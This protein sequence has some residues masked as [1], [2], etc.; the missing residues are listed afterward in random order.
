MPSSFSTACLLFSEVA[1][2]L[3]YTAPHP[4]GNGRRISPRGRTQ[5]L[6][7]RT[8]PSG[9]RRRLVDSAFRKAGLS[10]RPR[11]VLDTRDAVYEAVVNRMGVGFM[12]RHGT[13]RTDAIRRIGVIG[14]APPCAESVFRLQGP[15]DTLVTAFFAAA[16][17]F[18]RDGRVNAM[19][20]RG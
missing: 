11:L 8:E 10:P 19:S 12:W 2:R 1:Q 4:V 16:R 18:H 5:R 17:A 20:G 15:A 9:L 6:I 7:R 13:G 14:I 3:E